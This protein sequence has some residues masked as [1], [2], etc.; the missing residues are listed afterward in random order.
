ME[1]KEASDKLLAVDVPCGCCFEDEMFDGFYTLS[2]NILFQVIHRY[3]GQESTQERE[4]EG[5][6]GY[7]SH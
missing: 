5:R 3:A 6:Y 1:F 4:G 7:V 2:T